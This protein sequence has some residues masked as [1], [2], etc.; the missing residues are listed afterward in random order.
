MH[1]QLIKLNAGADERAKAMA[2]VAAIL[3]TLFDLI[4]HVLEI[5]YIEDMIATSAFSPLSLATPVCF[6][7]GD[8]EI[9]FLVCNGKSVKKK[10]TAP[11]LTVV[12]TFKINCPMKIHSK[13][14]S[15]F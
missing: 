6:P 4:L 8:V 1:T 2:A 9:L 14:D 3:I 10:I 5:I 12:V 11:A 13:K 7:G 15:L